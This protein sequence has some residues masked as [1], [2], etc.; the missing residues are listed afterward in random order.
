MTKWIRGVDLSVYQ[1][2]VPLSTWEKLRHVG[3]N[4]VAV[5]GSWHGNTGNQYAEENLSK[6]LAA[7]FPHL[8]TYTVISPHRT[9][10]YAVEQA[11]FF[12]G[13]MW[14]KLDFVSIDCELRGIT[15]SQIMDAVELC[16]RKGKLV[17]IYTAWWFWYEVFGNPSD[18]K[19]VP[20][21]NAYYD[22]DEDIDFDT[23][24]YGGW[25]LSNVVGEQY[26]GTTPM[27]GTEV[28]LNMFDE[29]WLKGEEMVPNPNLDQRINAAKIFNEVLDNMLD[30]IVPTVA[31]RRNMRYLLEAWRASV[32][33]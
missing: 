33:E 12:C 4:D 13:N 14:D 30:G 28:D 26:A 29:D 2:S 10:K 5:V 1:G 25:E 20:L 31:R 3:G 32:G 19:S 9:G 8:G 6:A 17:N 18:L 27:F 23:L 15:T 22:S 21:W 24:P 16:W 11:E 7:G